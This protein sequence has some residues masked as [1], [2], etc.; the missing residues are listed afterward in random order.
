MV[1]AGPPFGLE[2]IQTHFEATAPPLALAG[3][4]ICL[5]F[6]HVQAFSKSLVAITFTI[7]YY[8]CIIYDL[9]SLYNYEI[10][11]KCWLAVASRIRVGLRRA[12]RGSVA[13]DGHGRRSAFALPLLKASASG[14]LLHLRKS[15]RPGDAWAGPPKAHHPIL[16]RRAETKSY[17]NH[18]SINI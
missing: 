2:V 3:A 12:L 1:G 17:I 7:I 18:T 13:E 15:S 8:I 4:I 9:L 10:F 6:A 14:R 5:H 16:N 11:C